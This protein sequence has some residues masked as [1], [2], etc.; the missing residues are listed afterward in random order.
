[1][2]KQSTKVQKYGLFGGLVVAVVFF[3]SVNMDPNNPLVTATAAI[4]L[5]MA[6]WWI[7]ITFSCYS[8]DS[9]IYV[10]SI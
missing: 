3:F 1:M 2:L 10:S 8:F 4:A 9:G 7:G 6:I 5:L